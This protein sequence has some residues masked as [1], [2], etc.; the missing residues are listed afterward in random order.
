MADDQSKK[1]PLNHKREPHPEWVEWFRDYS[2]PIVGILFIGLLLC[3][4]NHYGLPADW[5]RGKDLTYVFLNVAQLIA[6]TLAG[7]WFIFK[8]VKGRKFQESLIPVVSGKLM[9]VDDKTFLLADVRV[10]NIGE[11]VIQFA[12]GASSLKLFEYVDSDAGE[13]VAV[14]DRY[15]T[16]FEALDDSFIEPNEVI[17]KTRFISLP[18]ETALGYR[19]ELEIISNHRKKFTWGTSTIVEKPASNAIISTETSEDK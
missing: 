15:V 3:W 5:T 14:M 12:P 11:S 6:L 1:V 4:A 16:Q 8:F 2:V 7:W 17:Q 19:L 9:I 13:V 18:S 10:E